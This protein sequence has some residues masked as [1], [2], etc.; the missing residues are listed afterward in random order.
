MSARV[1]EAMMPV[2]HGT[3]GD[4]AERAAYSLVGKTKSDPRGGCVRWMEKP[5]PL[6]RTSSSSVS[7]EE[8]SPILSLLALF[9][10]LLLLTALFRA[11]F[12]SAAVAM[13][14]E[15]EA[16]EAGGGGGVGPLAF[17]CDDRSET[18]GETE[19]P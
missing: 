14:F 6:P 7:V 13:R 2:S 11:V 10:F 5:A 17:C 1:N 12:D 4:I 8:S 9:R 19:G 18:A 15:T 16:E 3:S